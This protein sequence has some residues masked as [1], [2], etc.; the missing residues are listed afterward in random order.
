MKVIKCKEK[1]NNERRFRELM[2]KVQEAASKQKPRP[3]SNWQSKIL[4]THENMIGG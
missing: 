4:E 2:E 3:S 1:E